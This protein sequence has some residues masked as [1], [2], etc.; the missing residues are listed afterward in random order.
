LDEARYLLQGDKSLR[1]VVNRLYYAMFYAILA[2]LIFEP[3]AS[4]KHSG[5][6]S[7]FNKRFVKEGGFPK[8]LAR[9][10][11]LAFELRQQSDYKEYAKLTE[12]QASSLLGDAQSFVSEVKKHLEGTIFPAL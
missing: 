4:S 10:I 7:Y 3:Y 6:I 9:T 5:V 8:E 11:N 12:E 1:S 2:L